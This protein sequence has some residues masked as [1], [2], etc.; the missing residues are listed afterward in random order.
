M[1]TGKGG[2]RRDHLPAL[3]RRV[4]VDDKEVRTIWSRSDPHGRFKRKTGGFGRAKFCTEVA[5]SKI[6]RIWMSGRS[7]AE[8]THNLLST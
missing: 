2:H 3:A 6:T 4:E 5:H 8:N 1:R 7:G